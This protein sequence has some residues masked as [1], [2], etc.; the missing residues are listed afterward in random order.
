MKKLLFIGHKF[1]EKT[2]SSD[3]LIDL[4]ETKYQITKISIDLYSED[5]FEPLKK[6]TITDFNVLLFWQIKPTLKNF[7]EKF[8][9]A[10]AVFFPMYDDVRGLKKIERWYPYKN[11]HIINFCRQL[12]KDLLAAGFDSHYIQ[13]FP[14]PPVELPN[15]GN[16]QHAFFWNRSKSISTETL[17]DL[18]SSY[19]LKRL[20]IHKVLDPDHSFIPPQKN[21]ADHIFYSEWYPKKSDMLD[22]ILDCSLYIAPRKKE[23]IG[24]SFLEAMAMGRCVIAPDHPTMNEYITH[25]QTGI[26]YSLEKPAP[27]SL[28]DI[29]AIQLASYTFMQDGHK[30]WENNK[31]KILEWIES[32]L[33]TKHSTLRKKLFIRFLQRPIKIIKALKSSKLF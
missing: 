21:L 18:F 26:L 23:G 25:N 31:L 6:L 28:K 8:T 14:Q 3:F 32:P 19:D 30:Q 17:A 12:H 2:R 4:L 9:Y 16:P 1:H 24:M 13:Y 20:H 33:S 22:D 5:K 10:H 11:F 15:L 29:Q 27:I 7:P